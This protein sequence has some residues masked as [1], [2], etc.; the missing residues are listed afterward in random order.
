MADDR[1]PPEGELER[2]YRT[3]RTGAESAAPTPLL[4]AVAV[5]PWRSAARGIEVFL[6]ERDP[7]LR[8]LGGYRCFPGGRVDP[9]DEGP[10][11][12][13]CREMREETGVELDPTALRPVARFVTPDLHPIR[14]DATYYLAELP[15]DAR[16]DHRHSGGELSGGEWIA[17]GEALARFDR[18]E[19]LL[20][21][22]VLRSLAALTD[23]VSGAEARLAQ[24]AADDKGE[25]RRWPLAGAIEV[26]VLATPTLPPA[27]HTSCYLV[28]DREVVAIDPGSPWPAE[29]AILDGRIDALRA[30]GRRLVAV[31]LTHHHGDHVGGAA[32][33]AQRTGAPI[34]AHPE[35]ARRLAGAIPIGRTLA[36]GEVIALAGA[37][38][39]RLRAVYTPGHAPGHLCFLEE[40]TGFL[41]A[42]D[43]VASIGTI[44]IDP[45]EGDMA[46]YLASLE[47]MRDLSPRA[48]LPAHG[49]PIADPALRIEE[50][51]RHRLWRERRVADALAEGPAT[52]AALTARAYADTPIAL[53]GLA[54]RSL[55]AHLVKLERDGRARRDGARWSAR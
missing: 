30:A 1:G 36:D 6:A 33:L 49:A 13:A 45:S 28:G 8:L 42:G 51:V 16:P 11:A 23:G 26:I 54:E 15:P 50:Y 38:A 55:I 10:L 43:M 34:W 29:Q 32:A 4:P 3:V 19:W 18:G 31:L 53:H 35:T 25:P 17:P 12:A 7:S 47:R 48:L 9:E 39:R 41:I 21:S 52:T 22:P 27:A 5:I 44:L 20:P 24:A 37:P 40:A 2:L 14:Y 46:A